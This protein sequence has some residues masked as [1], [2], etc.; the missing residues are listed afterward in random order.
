MAKIKTAVVGLL[1]AA[2]SMLG[3][4]AVPLGLLVL[5]NIADYITGIIAAPYRGE[6]RN[7]SRGFAGIVRKVCM[8][9]LVGVGAVLDTLLAYLQQ[10]TGLGLPFSFAVACVVCVWLLVNEMIS[11]VENIDALG[12]RVPFLMPVIHWLRKKVESGTRLPGGGDEPGDG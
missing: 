10:S 12:V 9:L 5:C 6:A 1:A 2:A 11:I 7:S 3:C 4:L 8:W